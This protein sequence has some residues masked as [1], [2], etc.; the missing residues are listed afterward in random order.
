H[1]RLNSL[2]GQS[3][4]EWHHDDKGDSGGVPSVFGNPRSRLVGASAP[5]KPSAS[6]HCFQ[7]SSAC[8][9]RIEFALETFIRAAKRTKRTHVSRHGGEGRRRRSDADRQRRECARLDGIDE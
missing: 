8:R 4:V 9:T 3:P 6:R 5:E 2:Y 1:L 7:A